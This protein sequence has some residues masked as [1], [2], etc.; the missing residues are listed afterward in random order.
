[1]SNEYLVTMLGDF[2]VT[3]GKKTISDRQNRSRKPWNLIEYL[4]ARRGES[5]D[6]DDLLKLIWSDDTSD[7]SSGALKVLLH[8]ARKILDE[9]APDDNEELIVLK[10][11]EYFLNREYPNVFYIIEYYESLG[12]DEIY[13]FSK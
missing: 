4:F 12:I 6:Q 9:L 11:G 8:R 2:T 13:A 5:S 3:H 1:M 7:N 10:K